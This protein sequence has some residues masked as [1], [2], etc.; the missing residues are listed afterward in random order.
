VVERPLTAAMPG[1]SLSH[2]ALIELAAEVQRTADAE[3]ETAA[4]A[5][6]KPQEVGRRLK[7]VK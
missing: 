5:E 3:C 6:Q 2:Y 4:K 7:I 1:G